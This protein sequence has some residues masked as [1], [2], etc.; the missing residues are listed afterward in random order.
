MTEDEPQPLECPECGAKMI[1][2]DGGVWC[3]RV[4]AVVILDEPYKEESK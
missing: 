3:S 1:L 4:Y 2:T